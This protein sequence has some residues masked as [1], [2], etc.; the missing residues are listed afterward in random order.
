MDRLWFEVVPGTIGNWDTLSSSAARAGLEAS[1][2]RRHESSDEW[3]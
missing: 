1:V 2:E 3:M